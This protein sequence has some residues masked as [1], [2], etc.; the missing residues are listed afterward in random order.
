M[1]LIVQ[2]SFVEINQYI[3]F[4][5]NLAVNF[6][7]IKYFQCKDQTGACHDKEKMGGCRRPYCTLDRRGKSG[8]GVFTL[9]YSTKYV[10]PESESRN[11]DHN[12]VLPI[13]QISNLIL[14]LFEVSISCLYMWHRQWSV[15]T[16]VLRPEEKSNTRETWEQIQDERQIWAKL[17]HYLTHNPRGASWRSL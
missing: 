3:C 9:S 11:K 6:S 14:K 15:F 12:K 17:V 16:S 5:C 4:S 1:Y 13:T 7:R 8:V 2:H 10:K